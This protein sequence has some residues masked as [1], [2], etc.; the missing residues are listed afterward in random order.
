[1]ANHRIARD[2]LNGTKAHQILCYYMNQFVLLIM[3]LLA[4]LYY[5]PLALFRCVVKQRADPTHSPNSK[6]NAAEI[7]RP[8]Q[9]AH[10]PM[11][12]TRLIACKR[13]N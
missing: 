8:P 6:H 9:N 5:L 10:T 11:K 2:A 3:I 13:V 12:N 7:V 4:S 1:M